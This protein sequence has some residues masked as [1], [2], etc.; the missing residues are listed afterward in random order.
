METCEAADEI[1]LRIRVADESCVETIVDAYRDHLDRYPSFDFVWGTLLRYFLENGKNDGVAWLL[2]HPR[3]VPAHVRHA[4]RA[5]QSTLAFDLP[6][7]RVQLEAFL[8]SRTTDVRW[9]WCWEL[10]LEALDEPELSEWLP[11]LAQAAKDDGL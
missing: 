3:E 11:R 5:Y 7:A 4:V 6:E 10:V 2:A 9:T 8:N 1:R